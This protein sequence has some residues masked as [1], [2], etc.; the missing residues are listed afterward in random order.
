MI[1]YHPSYFTV[2]FRLCTAVHLVL[3]AVLAVESSVSQ[4]TLAASGQQGQAAGHAAT[5]AQ[6]PN[7]ARHLRKL[8]VKSVVRSLLK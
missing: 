7:C 1:T 3:S 5:L 6:V 4:S 8:N 2:I